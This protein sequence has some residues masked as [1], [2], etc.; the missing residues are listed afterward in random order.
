[1]LTLATE[2]LLLQ[3][4]DIEVTI[5][6]IGLSQAPT[7]FSNVTNDRFECLYTCLKAVKHW[8][9]VFLSVAPAEFV[10]TSSFICAQLTHCCSVLWN[11]STF[12]FLSGWDCGLVQEHIDVPSLC[13]RM[14]TQF[15]QVKDA[16]GLH[17]ESSQD[18]DFFGVMAYRVSCMKDLWDTIVSTTTATCDTPVSSALPDL[19]NVVLGPLWHGHDSPSDSSVA[20]PGNART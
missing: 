18:R 14:E 6:E 9:D 12:K 8:F 3:L 7:I 20:G 13:E 19:P 1:M 10:G 4:H 11:L 5:H 15:A 16:A 2:C 17:I